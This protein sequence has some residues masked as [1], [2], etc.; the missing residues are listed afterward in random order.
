MLGP[1]HRLTQIVLNLLLNAVDALDGRGRIQVRARPLGDGSHALLQVTDDGPGIAREMQDK[2]FD[3]FTTT[4]PVGKG[5]GLGLA[6]THAIV[7]GLGGR[8]EGKNRDEGGACFEVQLRYRPRQ[9]SD[10][11]ASSV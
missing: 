4:K 8:I 3:P 7:E 9:L 11:L 6:V 5:T 10:R 1:R 2:L